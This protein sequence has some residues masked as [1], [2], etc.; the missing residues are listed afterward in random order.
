MNKCQQAFTP[1]AQRTCKTKRPSCWWGWEVWAQRG[2]PSPATSNLQAQPI[3]GSQ[4]LSTII[5]DKGERKFV[6]S[7]INV[8]KATAWDDKTHCDDTGSPSTAHKETERRLW[9]CPLRSPWFSAKEVIIHHA[10]GS[11]IF[12]V[13][14][15]TYCQYRACVTRATSQLHKTQEVG[16]KCCRRAKW[17]SH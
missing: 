14:T 4:L 8:H 11:S 3:T 5:R 9:G 16:G 10:F 13:V 12:I 7:A 2:F 15:P 17:N 1:S 6:Q